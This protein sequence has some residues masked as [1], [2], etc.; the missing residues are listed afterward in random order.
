MVTEGVIGRLA[1]K[2]GWLIALLVGLSVATSAAPAL[3]A[4][5]EHRLVFRGGVRVGLDG[6][7][8]RAATFGA[9]SSAHVRY[10]VVIENGCRPSDPSRRSCPPP[11]RTLTVTLND[12]VVF[13]SDDEFRIQRVVLPRDAVTGDDNRLVISAAGVPKAAARVAIVATPIG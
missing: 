7:G 12:E 11:V 3:A 1:A 4:T 8:V 5:P 6:N 2:P 13:Q 9:L 10:G